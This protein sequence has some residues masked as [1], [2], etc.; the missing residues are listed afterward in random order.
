MK[1]GKYVWLFE[2]GDA[3]MG[4]ELGPKGLNLA[5]ISQLPVSVP[6][7]LTIGSTACLE[8]IKLG[9]QMPD[10]LMDSVRGGLACVGHKLGRSYGDSG[11]PLLVS[12]RWNSNSSTIGAPCG[13]LNVGMTDDVASSL[14]ALTGSPRFVI[15]CYRRLAR[16]LAALVLQASGDL[17]FDFRR[18]S[19]L[20]VPWPPTGN[21]HGDYREE[22]LKIKNWFFIQ[23]GIEFPATAMEQI[24]LSIS[25]IYKAWARPRGFSYRIKEG[26]V[27]IPPTA[28]TIQS[29]VFGNIGDYCGSGVISGD[30]GYFVL[31]AQGKE[32]G[33]GLRKM[34][35]IPELEVYDPNLCRQIAKVREVL[36][37]WR[38]GECSFDF[39]VERGKLY[40][41]RAR[42]LIAKEALP[43]FR[44]SDEII[45][46][47]DDERE[48]GD[49]YFCQSRIRRLEK[50][51][52]ASS[53]AA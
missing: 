13:A 38:D 40:V 21:D 7:G 51:G 23:T 41:L 52:E 22:Y 19:F 33:D 24:S 31:G 6:P 29:M 47:F 53:Q 20:S 50:V 17:N 5:E 27:T 39:T 42:R 12:I 3:A 18:S 32:I 44:S 45:P 16:D 48:S 34:M 37:G 46:E 10:H 30:D 8:Y 28:I 26:A 11:N 25:S 4:K 49:S 14:I 1:Q 43:K 15:D 2:Q 35:S 9:G 36:S